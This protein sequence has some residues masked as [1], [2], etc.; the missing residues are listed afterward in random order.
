MQ[1]HN[2][3]YTSVQQVD[4]KLVVALT[5]INE[6]EDIARG[7]SAIARYIIRDLSRNFKMDQSASSL[8]KIIGRALRKGH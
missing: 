1:H 2:L 4:E 6:A 3:Q 8:E 5:P 7:Q